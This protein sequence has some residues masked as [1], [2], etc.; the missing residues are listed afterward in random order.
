M[1]KKSSKPGVTWDRRIVL[2]LTRQIVKRLDRA[3][4]GDETRLDVI[5]VAIDRELVRRGG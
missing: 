2:P 3:R 5:R 1:L 4:E